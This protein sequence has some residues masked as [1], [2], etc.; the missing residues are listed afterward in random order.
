MKVQHNHKRIAL[1]LFCLLTCWY[2]LT[3]NGY[4]DSIDGET[5]FHVAEGLVE[6]QSFAQ[7]EPEQAGSVPRALT[8]GYDGKL[9]AITGPM[10]SLLAIP[11]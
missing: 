6:R 8:R 7:L 5:V 2:W 11:L 1:A 4:I 10:Q 3:T 9:Y